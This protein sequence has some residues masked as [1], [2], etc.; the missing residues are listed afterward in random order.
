M[1]RD[2]ITDGWLKRDFVKE[3]LVKPMNRS[4]TSTSNQA[5]GGRFHSNQFTIYSP[6][7]MEC[8]LCLSAKGPTVKKMCGPLLIYSLHEDQVYLRMRKKLLF[9]RNLDTNKEF[10]TRIHLIYRKYKS[11]VLCSV[12]DISIP[13]IG[14][15]GGAYT[16]TGTGR[17]GNSPCVYP[18]SSLFVFV[19]IIHISAKRENMQHSTRGMYCTYCSTWTVERSL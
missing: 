3:I 9:H 12:V 10:I 13:E 14:E 6:A 11:Q 18:R 4:A 16:G 17:V 2:S 15:A 19:P 1:L 7:V 8:R 5:W